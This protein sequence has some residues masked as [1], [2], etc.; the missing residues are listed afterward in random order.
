MAQKDNDDEVV[1]DGDRNLSKSIKSKN[2]K[3]GIQMRIEAT[4]EPTFLTS[5]ARE[6]FNQL[7]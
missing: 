5:D 4:E 2:I 7:R 3:S 6:A 1:G